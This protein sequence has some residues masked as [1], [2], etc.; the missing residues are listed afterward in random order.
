ME[1]CLVSEYVS[2]E[3]KI[4]MPAV[5]FDPTVKGPFTYPADVGVTAENVEAVIEVGGM[6]IAYWA[7]SMVTY[8]DGVGITWRE[9]PDDPG[10]KLESKTIT[11]EQIARGLMEI[12]FGRGARSD[13]VEHARRAVIDD[14]AGEIDGEI[15][16]VAIQYAL[17]DEIV[18]G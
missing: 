6:V 2:G 14:D 13:L 17:F 12:A 3:R 1:G 4:T 8:S 7:S 11:W 16:D 10:S 18:Y 9:D 15:A 5:V